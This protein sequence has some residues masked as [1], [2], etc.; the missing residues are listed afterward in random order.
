MYYVIR[1]MVG[2]TEDGTTRRV[3]LGPASDALSIKFLFSIFLP[4][5]MVLHGREIFRGS[6]SHYRSTF[7]RRTE[8]SQEQ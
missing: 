6:N 8:V 5:A 3:R 7:I 4:L 1:Y 2:T